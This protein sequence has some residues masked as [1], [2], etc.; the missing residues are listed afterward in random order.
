MLALTFF[1]NARIW[2]LVSLNCLSS[3]GT[4]KPAQGLPD[5][6]GKPELKN[7]RRICSDTGTSIETRTGTGT[8]RWPVPLPSLKILFSFI[9]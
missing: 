6:G 8:T 2:K 9:D 7:T 4:S 3:L 5:T 1:F